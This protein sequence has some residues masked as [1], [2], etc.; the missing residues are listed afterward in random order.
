M[1]GQRAAQESRW[2][3]MDARTMR[4]GAFPVV[5]RANAGNVA[6]LGTLASQFGLAFISP[7]KIDGSELTLDVTIRS[8]CFPTRVKVL[9]VDE[10][11]HKDKNVLRYFTQLVG[12]AA[13]DWDLLVRYVD[14][15]PEPR[16]VTPP[17]A[18]D[19]DF[20]SLPLRVQNQIVGGLVRARRLAPPADG[21]AP[22]IRYKTITA[23]VADERVYTDIVV[24][25]RLTVNGET[26]RY[27]TRFRVHP[28]ER[29]E[30][31]K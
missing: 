31:L 8:R 10:V 16:A 7:T 15:K 30:E 9:A 26:M 14:D 22:L 25:S 27:D 23:R 3:A 6:V 2:F 13:D 18:P 29:I 24:H 12:I 4:P 5:V 17:A 20:R 1:L 21:A 28:D 11:K 19:E